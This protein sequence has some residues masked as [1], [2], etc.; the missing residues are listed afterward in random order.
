M[1][2]YICTYSVCVYI[3]IYIYIYTHIYTCIYGRL[4]R[5]L[6][7]D[8]QDD[9]HHLGGRHL[10]ALTI[11]TTHV[12]FS[13]IRV[14]FTLEILNLDIMGMVDQSKTKERSG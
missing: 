3:Y 14:V 5:L 11:T 2:V 6:Y 9:L 4:E 1:R 8:A 10:P 7:E 12:V 13:F